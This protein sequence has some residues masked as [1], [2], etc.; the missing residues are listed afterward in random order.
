MDSATDSTTEQGSILGKVLDSKRAE[1]QVLDPIE[2]INMIIEHA[3]EQR[4]R[5]IVRQRHGLGRESMTLDA[6]GKRLG[7]TRERVRQIAKHALHKLGEA[8]RVFDETHLLDLALKEII[9]RSGGVKEESSLLRE[10]FGSRY[11]DEQRLALLFF[12]H[13]LS[14][15][16][17]KASFK[18]PGWQLVGAPVD[19]HQILDDIVH[20]HVKNLDTPQSMERLH[21]ALQ[22]YD[23]FVYWRKRFEEAWPRED[24]SHD[25]VHIIRSYLQLS[26]KVD[27]NPFD[28]WGVSSSNM[29]RPRRMGDKIYLV[30]RKHKEPLHFNRITELINE[31]G[32]DGRVAYHPTVHNE[33]ILDKRFVLV[34]R[35]IYALKEWGYSEGTVTDVIRNVLASSKEPLS[36]KEIVEEVLRERVVKE[37][38][39]LLALTD[40]KL[41]IRLPDGRYTLCDES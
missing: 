3:L 2:I 35:G 19:L 5:E 34:G 25:W 29:V 27:S 20:E 16:I 39:V 38:T 33:L 11:S 41:F 24:G 14:E 21:D 8:K 18:K 12:I 32:F 36:R 6:I 28:E 23:D 37:G 17:S 31:Y 40:K 7:I 4:E 9:N 10:F 26:D 22:E 30:L 15:F 13:H 1:G